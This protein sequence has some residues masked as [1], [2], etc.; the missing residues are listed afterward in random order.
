MEKTPITVAADAAHCDRHK[1][2]DWVPDEGYQRHR[3]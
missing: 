3:I 2:R 1:V